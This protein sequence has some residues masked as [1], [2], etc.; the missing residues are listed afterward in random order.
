MYVEREISEKFGGLARAYGIVALVGARQSGKTTFL[1]EHAKNPGASYVLFDDPDARAL[2]DQDV[3]KF[4]KQFIEGHAPVILD[5][6]QY[7]KD[8]GRNLKYLADSGRNLWITSSSEILLGKEVLSFLVGR[9]SVLRLYPFSLKE[10]LSANGTQELTGQVLSRSVWEHATYGGYPKVVTTGDVEMKKTILS[11][12]YQT[13][14]FKDVAR[15]FSIEDMN[16]LEKLAKYL[17]VNAGGAVSYENIGSEIGLSFQTLKKY[18]DAM[19]KSHI[20]RRIPPFHTNKT[21]EITRQPKA[22]FVDTGLRNAV[23]KSFAT[24]VDGKLFENYVATELFKAGFEPKYWRTKT[25]AEVDFI[26]EKDGKP[27][28]IEVKLKTGNSKIESGLRAFIDEYS[29]ENALVVAYE[30][31]KMQAKRGKTRIQF[32]DVMQMRETLSKQG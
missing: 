29:P 20:I 24:Q 12:L 23:A 3:K 27:T 7:C 19:E 21:K 32:T 30:G 4:E 17:A 2:F 15:T 18:L 16:S 13:M 1:K 6:V 10:F 31:K 22:Y 11:D 5:E 14:L 9:V 28:P 25:G 8:A 26:V